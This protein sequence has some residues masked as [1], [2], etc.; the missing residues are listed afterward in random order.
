MEF[1]LKIRRRNLIELS[2]KDPSLVTGL[3]EFKL[4]VSRYMTESN[5]MLCVYSRVQVFYTFIQ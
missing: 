4:K 3:L 2:L 1:Y 5:D